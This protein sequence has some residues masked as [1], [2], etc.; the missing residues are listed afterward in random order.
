[1]ENFCLET[2]NF[3]NSVESQFVFNNMLAG[4]DFDGFFEAFERVKEK[5]KYDEPL[6]SQLKQEH[7]FF[8]KMKNPRGFIDFNSRIKVFIGTLKVKSQ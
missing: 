7:D 2:A 5:L 8:L 1:M 6:Y 3:G 4:N